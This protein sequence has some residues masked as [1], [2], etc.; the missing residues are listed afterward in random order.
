MAGGSLVR[1]CGFGGRNLSDKDREIYDAFKLFLE[2]IGPPLKKGE[3]GFAVI[4]DKGKVGAA[5]DV[6]DPE[7][8]EALTKA[9]KL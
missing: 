4:L 7:L 2:N 3:K 5:L 1:G 8:A 9:G 6:L